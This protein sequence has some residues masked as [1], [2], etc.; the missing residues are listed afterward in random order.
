M[1][2]II[3]G[4]GDLGFYLAKILAQEKHDITVVDQNPERLRRATDSLDVLTL[5]GSGT[6]INTLEE[7]GAESADML[8]AVTSIEEI[9]L[10]SCLLATKL[11]TKKR[12]IR[13]HDPE[14][15]FAKGPMK[16]ED[17]GIDRV[18]YPEGLAAQEIVRL[19]RRSA[20]TEVLEF[21]DGRVQLLGIRLDAD[22]PLINKTLGEIGASHGD[23]AFR[24]V[25]IVRGLHTIVPKRD[26][27][28]RKGDQLFVI[29]KTDSVPEMLAVCGKKAH[30]FKNIM[31]LG[32]GE[33]G[34][35][36]A[37][38]LE[39]ELSVK[40]LD[41]N[42]EHSRKSA[43]TLRKTMVIHDEGRDLDVMA[44]E[45]IMD[46]DAYIASSADEENNIISCLMAKHLGVGKTIAHV[47]KLD[48]VP[49]ANTIGIDALVNRKLSAAME[50][51][52][53][54]RKGEILSVATLHGVDAEVIELIAQEGSRVTKKEIR[55]LNFPEG[56]IIG[57]VMHNGGVSIP[58]GD[59]QIEALDRVVVFTLPHAIHDVERLFN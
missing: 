11:G 21:A 4:M 3:V 43:E 14:F 58:V 47:E 8:I 30:S 45:G 54:I 38:E 1:K 2:I 48:Y 35:R 28:F 42:K 6:R 59:S 26:N 39:D 37:M 10:T 32:G 53:F 12:I 33:I 9:N 50:I 19:I 5:E 22:S 29:S 17:F 57:C 46:M 36:V 13:V 16:A 23:F 34:H 44:A 31:I 55:H 27:A 7:A 51:L 15:L 18:I 56:A 52:R 40:L 24:V 49:I 25:C 20:A 41:P